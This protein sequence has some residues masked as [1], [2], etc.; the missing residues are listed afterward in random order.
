MLTIRLPEKVEKR[1]QALAVKTG[2][3]KSYY[4]REAIMEH[5]EDYYLAVHRVENPPE[6][7][8]LLDELE[9]GCDL[10]G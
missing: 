5:L 9:Q 7:I 3:T 4:A 10:E 2:I 6:R 8:W 1:L